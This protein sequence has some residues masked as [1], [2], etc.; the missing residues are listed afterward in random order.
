MEQP[1]S[2]E[3]HRHLDK[4]RLDPYH[5]TLS[6]MQQA[7]RLGML[8]RAG[9]D[10]IQ[11]QVMELLAAAVLRYTRGESS[12][13]KN[14]T[15]QGIMLS[16]FY[17][18]DNCLISL[19]HPDLALEAL[20]TQVLAD[21]YRQGLSSL[22]A[23]FEDTAQ[24]YANLSLRK[25]PIANIAY[26]ST[27]DQAL[28]GFFNNYD[29]RFAAH[30]TIAD[31]DYPLLK[32][33]MKA[34]GLF[35]IRR[36]LLTLSAENRFC[37]QYESRELKKLLAA[38]AGTYRVNTNEA[39]I[40]IF[41][42]TATNALFSGLAGNPHQRLSVTPTQLQALQRLLSGLG[43]EQRL[44]LLHSQV[45]ELVVASTQ[46]TAMEPEEDPWASQTGAP[47]LKELMDYLISILMPRLDRALEFGNLK[48]VIIV[49][50]KETRPKQQIVFDA[51]VKMDDDSFRELIA[52]IMECW[53]GK[54]KAA[55]I[56]ARSQS[57]ADFIDI[58]EAD[59]LYDREYQDLYS[60]L[61]EMELAL[62][63]RMVFIEDLRADFEGF[64]L[65]AAVNKTFD[66]P[67][68]AEFCAFLS[69]LPHKRLQLVDQLMRS[70]LKNGM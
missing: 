63:A 59:C 35:Y 48:N 38:Y 5:Y 13:V 50:G 33:D 64:S 11:A 31:I 56:T 1:F 57:L 26:Q 32:D 28:P 53:D 18:L 4:S 19:G 67:W 43:L 36:Y 65:S 40:N 8:N 70:T 22:E 37:E 47:S 61:G 54:A 51:G 20:Q 9:M 55:L 68:Q 29:P 34:S 52:E 49:S 46:T 21:L 30:D 2:I 12:S 41:E 14:E 10:A 39:L 27:L 25:L 15:A 16:L 66:Y 7:Y 69:N 60:Q 17:S 42:I 23:C 45:E 62:L 6:L 44:E 24:I 3:K 58:L